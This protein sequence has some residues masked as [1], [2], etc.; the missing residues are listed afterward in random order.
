MDR[1]STTVNGNMGEVQ[2]AVYIHI[3][4]IIVAGGE[5]RGEEVCQISRIDYRL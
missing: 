5:K 1:V 4:I 3:Y 2:G